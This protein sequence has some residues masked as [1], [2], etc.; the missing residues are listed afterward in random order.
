MS[1]PNTPSDQSSSADIPLKDIDLLL[2]AEDPEFDRSLDEVRTVESD[3]DTTIDAG[4][5]DEEVADG[6]ELEEPKVG[7][8]AKI[9]SR[10]RHSLSQ[11]KVR[12]KDRLKT[13]LSQSVIFLR[14]RPKEFLFYAF[15]LSKVLIKNALIPLT[16][17]VHASRSQKLGV[18]F[19]IGITVASA[20]I[21][22]ANFKGVWLPN[23]N[24]PILHSFEPHADFVE[25]YNPKIEG[26]SFYTAFPQERYE[27]LFSKMKTNLKPGIDNPNP[28]GAFEIIVVLDSKDTAI[29]VRDR[30]VEFFD[31][32]QRVF[33]SE[34]FAELES[35]KGKGRLKSKLK[36]E[37]NQKLQQG[38]VKD[39]SFKTFILKP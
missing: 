14:T 32:L 12:T 10:L 2:A 39:I 4:A 25:T 31:Q 24:Q 30:Q 5:I 28:M 22:T 38:W 6:E 29:E 9:K 16:A 19:L 26:E 33:E 8:V 18:L 35:E 23:I 34:S 3:K 13:L 37:L 7:K 17:F 36:R 1:E 11:F 20:W 15:A 21:L 27:F